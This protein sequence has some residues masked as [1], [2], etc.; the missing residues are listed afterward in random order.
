M[1]NNEIGKVEDL[2][3]QI[4]PFYIDEVRSEPLLDK[5]GEQVMKE[6][7]Y[8]YI[9]ENGDTQTGT[10]PIPAFHN[11]NYTVEKPRWDLKSWDYVEQ[12]RNYKAKKHGI[13]KACESEQWQYHDEFVEWYFRPE[14]VRARDEFGEYIPDDPDT[15]VDESWVDGFT[16]EMYEA[17]LEP[18]DNSTDPA[19]KIHELDIAEAKMERDVGQY[20]PITV[21][22]NTYDADIVSYKK[23]TGSIGSWDTL[24]NDAAL[25]EAGAVLD[26]KLIWVLED[27]SMVP[28]TKVEL[29]EVIDAIAVRTAILQAQYSAVKG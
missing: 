19:V 22:V 5:D 15:E 13:L 1:F 20:A 3:I 24:V 12:A 23:M 21:G 4:Q 8:E 17:Q 14:P 2:P 26:G 29:Q 16:P 18:I 9:D 11:V 27:D 6:E 28:L 7:P 25:I 10:R